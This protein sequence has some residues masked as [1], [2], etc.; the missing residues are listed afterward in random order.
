MNRVKPWVNWFWVWINKLVS[1]GFGWLITK[2]SKKRTEPSPGPVEPSVSVEV[3]GDSFNSLFA[4]SAPDSGVT[5]DGQVW[6]RIQSALPSD[7]V[8]PHPDTIKVFE[9]M[10]ADHYA[11][12]FGNRSPAPGVFVDQEVWQ[13]I[14]ASLNLRYVIPD[15]ET[16][17]LLNKETAHPAKPRK[18]EDDAQ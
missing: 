17:R 9:P 7:Y 13:R 12:L 5:V 2:L 3:E 18:G 4:V 6:G 16:I 8:L 11:S 15:P 1:A 10:S 14:V